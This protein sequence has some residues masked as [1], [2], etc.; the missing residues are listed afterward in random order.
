MTPKAKANTNSTPCEICC[1]TFNKSSRKPLSCPFCNKTSCILCA[2]NFISQT[3]QSPHCMH[4]KVVW[5]NSFI[6]SNFSQTW[7]NKE[8]KH[9]REKLLF[10][11]ELAKIPETQQ[12]CDAA[13]QRETEKFNREK[14]LQNLKDLKVQLSETKRL[15]EEC[16]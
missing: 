5:N 8:Y 6:R 15:Y 11:I 7:L 16:N 14:L 13:K 3:S 4:C 9:I 12:F 1:D 10:D 2:K